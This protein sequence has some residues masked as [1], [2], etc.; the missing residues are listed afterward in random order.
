MGTNKKLLLVIMLLP[1]LSFPLLGKATI[2]RFSLTA[3]FIGLLF[4]IQ[5]LIAH[6]RGWW[7]VY[8]R[9]FPNVIGEIP[10]II[11]PFYI[12]SLW[13]L[14]YTFGKFLRYTLLNLAID[15][16]HI[17][18]FVAWLEKMGI[19]GLIRLKNTQALL[20]FSFNAL[21]MYGFQLVVDK[22]VNPNKPRWV[23]KKFL[24]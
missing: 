4:A 23:L 1:W 2:K 15:F 10:F 17:Y 16:F 8:E 24:S 19:A 5:S 7:R 14:K 22:K 9:L 13:I 21:L 20:L 6:R 18:A 3:S 12:G 11:G